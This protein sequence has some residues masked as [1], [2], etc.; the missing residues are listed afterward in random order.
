M[1][2]FSGA[3]AWVVACLIAVGALFAVMPVHTQ[4]ADAMQETDKFA[5]KISEI[6]TRL[7]ERDVSDE[8]FAQPAFAA[9][10]DNPAPYAAAARALMARRDLGSHPK[11][12]A[13]LAMQRLPV[14][15]FV[16]LVAATADSV[17]Q[18]QS[19]ILVLEAIAF[20]P[21]HLGQQA[22]VMHYDQPNVREL[23]TRLLTLPQL[24]AQRKER[25]RERILTGQAKLEYLDYRAMIGR[26]V[27]Q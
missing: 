23:F 2:V 16:A 11:R 7:S 4:R 5:A 9:I 1:T 14:D 10:Y 8:L 12:I 26:P 21:L 27:R 25:I 3:S 22:L 19:D 17:E 6:G 24:S 13:A 20:A 18:G 15:A